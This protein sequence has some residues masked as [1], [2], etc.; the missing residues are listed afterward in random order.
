MRRSFVF[1]VLSLLATACGPEPELPRRVDAVVPVAM[2][3]EA[4]SSAT[5]A[6]EPDHT[7]TRGEVVLVPMGKPFPP[8]LLDEIERSLRDELQ[9]EVRRHERIPLPRSAFYRPRKRYRAEK[10]LDHLLTLEPEAPRT[11]RMLGVT[12][13]DISTT[14]GKHHDWGIFGLGLM[15]GQAAV[16]SSHRLR[17]GAKDREHLRFRVATTA[18][19]E[20]GHTFG[21]AHCP[22]ERCPMQDAEGGIGNTDRSTGHLGPSCRAKLDEAF[23][24]RGD[25]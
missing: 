8:D 5:P 10:L 6:S 2:A 19:H 4:A 1:A 9:V 11:T 25:E 20:I 13:T 17:R 14:K 3:S 15:P 21:L 7:S 24:V 23:P 22:E 12:T 18:V 16:I